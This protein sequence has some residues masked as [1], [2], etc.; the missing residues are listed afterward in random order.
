MKKDKKDKKDKKS[1]KE[2]SDDEEAQVEVEEPKAAPALPV[3]LQVFVSGI[4]YEA[5]E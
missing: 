1:K 2:G 4:P 5:N 3:N